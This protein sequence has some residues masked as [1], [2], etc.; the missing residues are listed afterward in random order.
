MRARRLD[1]GQCRGA[2]RH[3]A[4]PSTTSTRSAHG[5]DEGVF[6]LGADHA[7]EVDAPGLHVTRR[8]AQR[9][10]GNRHLGDPA[11]FEAGRLAVH[12]VF[13]STLKPRS[14]VTRPSMKPPTRRDAEDEPVAAVVEGVEHHA[15]V[16]V[17]ALVGAV[18]AH[19]LGDWMPLRMGVVAPARDVNVVVVEQHPGFG[20]FGDRRPFLR[21]LLDEAGQRR[22][23]AICRVVEAAVDLIGVVT[24]VAPMTT[25]ANAAEPGVTKL[26]VIAQ[27]STRQAADRCHSTLDLLLRSSL[28][29]LREH[30]DRIHVGVLQPGR[31]AQADHRIHRLLVLP[32]ERG[33]DQA[34]RRGNGAHQLAV[35]RNH[36][37]IR[38]RGHVQPILRVDREAVT[39]S[40]REL[41]ELTLV[42]E[43][44][45]RLHVE[46][47]D[48]SH[49]CAEAPFVTYS[50]FSSALSTTPLVLSP[51]P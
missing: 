37:Q 33:R 8:V 13:Q 35:G 6:V 49:R 32:G 43:R 21:F 39:P 50:V 14:S 1:A 24:R 26:S 5:D 10:E 44:A 2:G 38:A 30:R 28:V 7:A 25:W 17:V 9:L 3:A 20:A 11:A 31:I 12:T 47:R 41:H 34:V 23:I 51:S 27:A 36:V 16:V 29:P 15:E 19:V 4:S 45:V 40:G 46:C 42:H 22:D 48:G 18:A